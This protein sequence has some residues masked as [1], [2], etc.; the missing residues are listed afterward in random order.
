MKN[1][2]IVNGTL[3]VDKVIANVAN[4]KCRALSFLAVGTG[5]DIT[6]LENYEER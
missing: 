1:V 3:Y 2:Q 4:E 5:A 6:E